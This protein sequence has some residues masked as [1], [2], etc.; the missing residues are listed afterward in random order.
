LDLGFGFTGA[1]AMELAEKA[2]RAV[3]KTNIREVDAVGE[4]GHRRMGI[5]KSGMTL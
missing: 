3:W 2:E 5:Y 4:V 1:A